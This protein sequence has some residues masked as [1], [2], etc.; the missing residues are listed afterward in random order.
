MLFNILNS[1]LAYFF[2]QNFKL[3]LCA[4]SYLFLTIYVNGNVDLV[5]Y[6]EKKLICY[7]YI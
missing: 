1:L 6:T 5:I 4:N 7:S 2:L 3:C